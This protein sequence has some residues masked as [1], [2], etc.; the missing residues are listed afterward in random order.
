MANK[1]SGVAK[2]IMAYVLCGL[3]ILSF[4]AF[5]IGDIFTNFGSNPPVARVGEH[6]IS[7]QDFARD[8]SRRTGQ[9]SEQFG[10]ALSPQQVQ[11]LG[12]GDQVL[13][14]LVAQAL[15]DLRG[16][17]MG[18]L[19]PR[20]VLQKELL[21]IDAFRNDS[22]VFDP[23]RF[24]NLLYQNN[25]SEDQFLSSLSSDLIRTQ[26]FA[27][28]S[29]SVQAPTAL[30]RVLA[31]SQSETRRV[32]Y[33]RITHAD[34]PTPAEPDRG[35][36]NNFYQG[37]EDQERARFMAPEYR[38][39]R[40]IHLD[41][42]A[43]EITPTTAEIEE[44]FQAQKDSLS[45][46]ESRRLS[47]GIFATEDAATTAAARIQAG[48][49]FAAVIT[50]L[51]GQAPIDLGN[52]T[53]GQ[54]LPELTGPAFATPVGQVTAPLSSP[55]GWHL[56]R[57]DDITPARSVTL[58]DV[59]PDVVRDAT[60]R[61]ATENLVGVANQLD[62]ALGGGATLDEAAKS[63]G[64]DLIAVP[65]L[66]SNG[67]DQGGKPVSAL[68]SRPDFLATLAATE[69]G[70]ESLLQDLDDGGWFILRVDSRTPSAPRT[71][72]EVK[73]DILALWQAEQR[74]TAANRKGEEIRTQIENDTLPT[75]G[76][77]V[78][79]NV[80]LSRTTQTLENQPAGQTVAAVF[81]AKVGEAII[82]EDENAT[83]VVRIMARN[84]APDDAEVIAALRDSLQAGYQR[85]LDSSLM[86]AQERAVGVTINTAV[87]NSVY[88]GGAGAQ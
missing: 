68:T 82:S 87:L 44:E 48:E 62:D 27:P 4:A 86:S 41:P 61:L 5:G 66:D 88:S 25:L 47:Q 20:T 13:G 26:L 1:D 51:S 58:D 18:L 59:R 19:V 72:D 40:Y 3:L 9:L 38:A 56:V 15:N 17:E 81:S 83:F 36:L 71:L 64:L 12:V 80:M 75:G 55:L 78:K 33:V 65:A 52:I 30:A 76:L 21:K 11:A 42:S 2:K 53:P 32:D 6:E 37:L 45:Q 31:R 69:A 85:E 57:V 7:R 35:D 24:Q 77:L 34:L 22:G 49:D 46:P 14:A 8:L 39:V 23:T 10:Q 28:M 79:Q 50:E 16:D 67:L 74:R 60:L 54:F 84:F 29:D 63:L 70:S 43:I 73:A